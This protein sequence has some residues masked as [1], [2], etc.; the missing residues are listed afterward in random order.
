MSISY[1]GYNNNT[2]TFE[3][4][5]NIT[6][7]SPVSIDNTNCAIN[8]SVGS[9][10]IGVCT[11]IRGTWASVQT[12]GYVEIPYEGM[13]PSTGIIKLVSAGGGKVKNGGADD[14]AV[15]K[16]IKVDTDNKIVGIIL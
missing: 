15:Y 13:D 7:G 14:I 6:V 8:A 11:A 1:K 10:F 16:V 5:G 4:D 9:D 2:I 12:D 3:T